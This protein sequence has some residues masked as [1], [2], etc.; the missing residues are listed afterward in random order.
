[1]SGLAF[2]KIITKGLHG[3]P[4]CQGL[5]TAHF[6]LYCEVITP[7]PPPPVTGGGGPYPG[8]AWNKVDGIQNFFKKVEVPYYLPQQTDFTKKKRIVLK[9]NI[10]KINVEKIY[11][12]PA[13]HADILI[14]VFNVISSTK[15]VVSAA[16]HNLQNKT[17]SFNILIGN[18]KNKTKNI[19]VV[20]KNLNNK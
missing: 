20:I 16:I 10:G 17:N 18:I 4:A 2:H 1:M 12:A 19:V 7:P 15:G 9:V 13:K 6:S 3:G 5:I 11:I 14:K 8:P